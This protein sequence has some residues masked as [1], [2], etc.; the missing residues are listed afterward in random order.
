MCEEDADESLV[1][2]STD[3]SAFTHH[4]GTMVTKEMGQCPRCKESL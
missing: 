1:F 4:C 3:D 2:D